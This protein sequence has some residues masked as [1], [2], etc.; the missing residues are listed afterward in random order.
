[1]GGRTLDSQN[2]RHLDNG[3]NIR[4]YSSIDM[5]KKK[6]F[7]KRE[8]AS[9]LR[10]KKLKP[11]NLKDFIIRSKELQ[12]AVEKEMKEMNEYSYFAQ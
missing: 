12:K 11:F 7:I 9:D 3:K 2:L 6:M 4:I 5:P 8:D 10:P 1:M